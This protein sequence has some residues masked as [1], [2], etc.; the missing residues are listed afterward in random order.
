MMNITIEIH[1]T[2]G[3]R[4]VQSGSFRLRGRKSEQVALQFWQQIKK[5]MSYHVQLDSVIINGDQD[6]TKLVV[7]LEHREWELSINDN[8]P[9]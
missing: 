9:F 6:I 8:L 7:E 3:T 4:A 2:A 1:Y 5:N